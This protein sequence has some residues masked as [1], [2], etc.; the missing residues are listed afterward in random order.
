MRRI[1]GEKLYLFKVENYHKFYVNLKL[2]SV[3]NLSDL[4]VSNNHNQHTREQVFLGWVGL[5]CVPYELFI[6]VISL[7]AKI[8]HIRPFH[9]HLYTNC[10]A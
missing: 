9:P 2:I 10:F 5:P 4:A 1:T 3:R 8:S 6:I 7:Y